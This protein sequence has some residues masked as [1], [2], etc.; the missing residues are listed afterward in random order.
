MAADPLRPVQAVTLGFTGP[1]PRILRSAKTGQAAGLAQM[2]QAVVPL[3]L[4]EVREWNTRAPGSTSAWLLLVLK[5][6]GSG[7]AVA[8][9]EE[10]FFRGAMQGALQR[11][12]AVRTALLAV[13]VLY[14]AV[15]FL[16]RATSVPH[17]QV[18]AL[19]GFVALGGFFS[20]FA[21]PMR[22]LD[23]FVALWLVG[24][25]L[26][27]VRWRWNNLAG[28]IGLHAGFVTVIAVFRR[29]TS[30]AADSPYSFL[31]GQFDGLLGL[32]VA[33]LTAAACLVVWRIRHTD[34]QPR[35]IP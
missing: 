35:R 30:P 11:I 13:P 12:G 5:G 20:G 7:I 32:W 29:V 21:A 19:S 34:G 8:L 2:C 4:L 24:V 23:A 15:H 1:W 25:L 17:D 28:C 14:A 6:L 22:I 31:V 9:I 3:L 16:G 26:A 10:T 27:L 33:A 18:D